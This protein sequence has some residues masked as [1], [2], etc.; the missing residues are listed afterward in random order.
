LNTLI[1][2]CKKENRKAQRQLY[3]LYADY[4][5]RICLR[6]MGNE[7]EAE[8][9][10]SETF[11]KV[12][13]KIQ[14]TEFE[15]EKMLIGWIRKIA[16]NECLMLIRKKPK[17]VDNISEK[18]DFVD[19]SQDILSDI[20][21]G[22]LFEIIQSL[23]TG[24]RTIFNLYIVEGYSHRE[25]AQQLNISEGTSKSQLNRAENEQ[26]IAKENADFTVDKTEKSVNKKTVVAEVAKEENM[27]TDV[28]S[29]IEEEHPEVP[30]NIKEIV[31]QPNDLLAVIPK[32]E[33]KVRVSLSPGKQK[34]QKN[35]KI[36]FKLPSIFLASNDDKSSNINVEENQMRNGIFQIPL[37]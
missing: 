7:P 15:N 8:D 25:I 9:C 19:D 30:E 2:Q 36:E 3:E 29:A 5:F 20:E 24:Y 1:E 31:S 4:V 13:S 26:L 28:F 10:V 17:D 37:K 27:L 6:Y 22:Y 16:V 23:P 32:S 34:N 33:I 12:F 35:D 11:L 21:T 14:S 18:A